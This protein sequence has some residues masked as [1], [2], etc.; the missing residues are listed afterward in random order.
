MGAMLALVWIVGPLFLAEGLL[1]VILRKR[2]A[3]N[4]PDVSLRR[5]HSFPRQGSP[6]SVAVLGWMI[7]AVGL[8]FPLL[9]YVLR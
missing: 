4:L 9:Y 1:F 3:R 5:P 8:L 7:S 6:R 2:V